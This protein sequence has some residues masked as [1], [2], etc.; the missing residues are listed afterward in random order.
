MRLPELPGHQ[1]ESLLGEDPFGWS[2]VASCEGGDRRVVKVLKAQAT[3]D[4]FLGPYLQSLTEDERALGEGTRVFQYRLSDDFAPTVYSMPLYGWWS[5]ESERWNL[6]SLKRIGH[7]LEGDL[8]LEITREL[9]RSIADT[10][11]RGYFHGG[12]NPSSVFIT[13]EAGGVRKVHL[14]DF[15]QIFMG[16]LQYLAAGELLFY[17]SP[18]Q[19]ATGDFSEDLGWQWDVYAFGVMAFQLLTGHLPRLDLLKKQ[20]DEN[21]GAMDSVAAIAYG[22][23]TGV[24]EHFL[25]RLEA[26]AE[27]EWPD[28][29]SSPFEEKL[30]MVIERCLGFDVD[31]RP[32]SMEM[33]HEAI[34][35]LFERYPQEESVAEP[36]LE[37]TVVEE[38]VAEEAAVEEPGPTRPTPVTE[39]IEVRAAARTTDSSAPDEEEISRVSESEEETIEEELTTAI[40]TVPEGTRKEGVVSRYVGV[41][42]RRYPA[43]KWQVAAILAL[44]GILPLSYFSLT[45]HIE[46]KQ[47]RNELTHEAAELQANVERQAAEYRRAITEKQKSSEQLRSELDEVE[48]KRSRLLGEAKLARQILR[49]TQ[50]NGDEFFRLVLE[51][52]DTDVPEFREGRA[53]ALEKAQ[54]HYERLIEVYGEAPDFIVSTANAYFYLGCIHRETGEFGKSLLSFGEAERRYMS[55]LDESDEPEVDF[56]RNLAIAK[57]ALGQLSM[58]NAK[59]TVARH[60]FTESSRYWGEVRSIAPETAMDAAVGIHENSLSIVECELA[61]YRLEAA[62]DGARSIASQLL[63]LQEQDPENDRIVGSLAKAFALAGRILQAQGEGDK[64]IEAFQQ[65]SNLY[66]KAVKLNA[67]IDAYRLGLGNSLA[68]EGLLENDIK[69]LESAIDVLGKVV[70]TNP[71]ESSFQKTLADVYGVLARNQRDGGHAENAI[72][73]EEEAISILQ[74]IIRQNPSAAPS[75]LLYSYSQRLAHLAELLGDAGEFDDSRAPLQESITVL[76]KISREEGALAEYRRALARSRGLAGF[77][78]LKSG[79]RSEAKE[80]LELAKAEWENYMA[81]NPEDSDAAQAVRW[82]ADQLR[83]LQ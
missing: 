18:E 33:V 37:E 38:T 77:A 36:E 67:A 70:V 48:D 29:A 13:G 68:S 45:T 32:S 19:L 76:E 6:T 46:L 23:L 74:P 25:G 81:E 12:L 28:A 9:A 17:V 61:I 82:T 54:E 5:E 75:D 83:G 56:V 4:E 1:Y 24:S 65:S 71:Y 60:F 57:R 3:N 49:Q 55:L 2:F 52:R 47:T 79:D 43:L 14:G 35:T 16:G 66:A 8:A 72:R 26:E 69:K 64:A 58:K 27:I 78:C 22:E 44:L 41:Y 73:L 20:C 42:F 21:P 40:T 62:L 53:E 34:E 10:H 7:L 80:H 63:K 15:G 59:F 30:R 50:D 51:N 39:P 31:D 11:R